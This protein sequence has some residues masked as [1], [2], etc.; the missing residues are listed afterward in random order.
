MSLGLLGLISSTVFNGLVFAGVY[1]FMMARRKTRK[2]ASGDFQPPVSLLKPLHGAE[3]N[4][5]AHIA[6]FFE[7]DY[8]NYEI[9]FCVRNANDP[10]L[11]IARRVAARYPA[12]PAKFLVT[13]E[14]TYI[15][16]KVSSLEKMAAAANTDIFIISDS[17]VHVTPNYIREVV[18]PFASE[19]VGAVTCL[20]RGV[21]DE[22]LWSKLEAAGMSVEMTSGVL[23]ANMM[24][25]MQFTLGPTMAVRRCCVSEMGGFAYLGPY[26]ADD[27]VLG[28]QVAALGYDVVLSDHVIDHVVLNLSFTA[29]VKHQVRWMKSTRFSR[30][31]GHFGTSLTFALPF[32]IIAGL[33]AWCMGK[34]HLALALLAYSALARAAMAVVIGAAVVEERHLLRTALLYPLRDLM[35]F[36]FWAASYT[37]STVLWRGRVYR[38]AEGGLMLAEADNTRPERETAM[39]V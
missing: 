16:A 18:A 22:G 31:K 17:D 30:P 7:Q 21:A 14:R 36:F 33:A 13:G 11:Q 27:F 25:G 32:G 3:P 29:S 6:S 8:S 39:T 26:C 37:G 20:Y 1:R 19:K 2:M 12:V 10:G 9:L 34:P 5:D 28:N 23:V 24:E 35:G 4:L 15:N 38:L